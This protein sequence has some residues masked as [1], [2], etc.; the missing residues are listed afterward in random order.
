MHGI[1]FECKRFLANALDFFRM[2]GV[3]KGKMGFLP[4]ARDFRGKNSVLKGIPRCG[5]QCTGFLSDSRG[6]LGEKLGF[7][8]RIGIFNQRRGVFIRNLRREAK[9]RRGIRNFPDWFKY[10]AVKSILSP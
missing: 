10:I 7:C 6:V 8:R 9:N 2:H 4:E 5:V 3:W 1:F